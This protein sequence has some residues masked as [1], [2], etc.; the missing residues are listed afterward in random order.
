MK[1]NGEFQDVNIRHIPV[2]W[3][4][5]LR[6]VLAGRGQTMRDWFIIEA[7]RTASAKAPKEMKK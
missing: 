7:A 5:Q 1:N 3:V 6:S 4:R 2:G